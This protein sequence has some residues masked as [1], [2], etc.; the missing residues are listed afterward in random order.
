MARFALPQLGRWKWALIVPPVLVLLVAAFAYYALPGIVRGKLEQLLSEQLGRRVSVGAVEIVPFVPRVKVSDLAVHARDG[1]AVQFRFASLEARAAWRSLTERAPIL[2]AVRL[3]DPQLD[4]RR[5]PDGSYDVDDIVRKFQ[6][7]PK[8]DDGPMPAF[9]VANIELVGGRIG[10]DDRLVG[11][12]HAVRD[13]QIRVP[14][15]SSMPVHEKVV[16]DPLLAADVNGTPVRI[17][18]HTRPFSDTRDSVLDIDTGTIDLMQY[19]GYVPKPPVLLQ[20]GRLVAKLRVTFSQPPS[21]GAHVVVNG[22]AG[23]FGLAL[24]DPAGGPLLKLAALEVQ[25]INLRLIDRVF[26][27][28]TVDIA[29][30]DLSV[31]R[32]R[33]EA[34][35]FEPVMAV[36]DASRTPA[37]SP[38]VPAPAPAAGAPA[39]RPIQW[40]V[41][42]IRLTSARV[43]F[44]DENFEPR[45]LALDIKSADATVDALASGPGDTARWKL[46]LA[47]S[48]DERLQG[49]GELVLTPFAVRGNASVEGVGLAPW[50]WL[51]ERQL[52]LDATSGTVRAATRFDVATPDGGAPQVKLEGL[53]AEL[54]DL[55]L[56]QR[57]DRA[58][59]VK[60]S[61]VSVDDMALDL[62][63]RRV[64]I[65][66][67]AAG[68]GR[69]LLRR[70]AGGRMNVTR[71]VDPE[72]IGAAAVQPAPGAA[73]AG[74]AVKPARPG[75]SPGPKAAPR[76]GARS[77]KPP[78]RRPDAGRP[79][80][81]RQG[82]VDVGPGR[83]Q[84]AATVVPR[85]AFVLTADEPTSRAAAPAA[86][87]PAVA[88]QPAGSVPPPATVAGTD[89]AATP[90]TGSTP[91][92]A[93]APPSA[94]SA[95]PPPTT[96]STPQAGAAPARPADWQ[97]RIAR[98]DV[99]GLGVD[100]QD[101]TAGRA[102]DLK[103]ESL[104]LGAESLSNAR[105]SRGRVDLKGRVGSD[106]SLAIA[107]PLTIEPLA[108]QLKVDLQRI[109]VVP[110][111]P[112]FSEFV[113]VLVSS[114][115]VSLRGDLDVAM[116]AAGAAP[117][118]TWKGDAGVAD[119]AAVTKAG[120]EDLMRWKRLAL[121][122]TSVTLDPL[123]LDLGDITL[124][125]FYARLKIDA[126][127][128]FNLQDL[129][130]RGDGDAPAAA[131]TSAATASGPAP[132][133]TSPSA[134]S[135]A[136]A[137]ASASPDGS[138]AAAP[139]ES[140][141]APAAPPPR[142]SG[143][144]PD[145]RIGKVTLSNGRIEFTDLFVRPNYSADIRELSGSISQITAQTS[146]DVE[147]RGRLD[148]SG[149]VEITGAINP[150]APSAQL[151]LQARASD[152]DLPAL[153]PYSAKYVG[154]GIDKGKLSAT[155]RYRVE[156]RQLSAEN[157]IVLDQLTFGDKVDSPTALKLPVLFAVALLKDRNGVIDVNL[158]ISGSLDDPQ[159]SI[160]GIVLRI[161]GNLIVKAV[162]SPFALLGA[163]A[164]GGEQLSYLEFAPG[165]AALDPPSEKKL[166]SLAKAL[167]ERPGLRMD[168]AGRADPT[169]DR[170]ALRRQSLERLLKAQKLR[171]VVSAGGSVGGLD[172]IV[173]APEERE[174]YLRQALRATAPATP[175]APPSATPAPSATPSADG[176]APAGT[177]PR[178][179]GAPGAELPVAEVERQLL[180][181][182][183][184]DDAALRELA[185]DRSRV[186][187]DW[188]VGQ[189]KIPGERLFLVAPRLGG[190][191]LKPGEEPLR[192]DLSLKG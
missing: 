101:Q 79:A 104:R 112:Y 148:P 52:A 154:Y 74:P 166:E 80:A 61:A 169:R 28:G 181:R 184:V 147:L 42:S 145:M 10:F 47:T 32:N 98:L 54:R 187:R 25:D 92:A 84:A 18:G 159:F 152:I 87:A 21:G 86:D 94:G 161:I 156:N 122:G 106:G 164:G 175:T 124:A 153:S 116:R 155:V 75:T 46:S 142:P 105:D 23:V 163:L 24:N 5:G 89:P 8:G 135:A 91:A 141:A 2:S 144:P 58:D 180:D 138:P 139:P 66:R 35:F 100:V 188:L 172:E 20:S 157:N 123:K 88:G 49:E 129:V 151:N 43:A 109:G 27:V 16:V 119:F 11:T 131:T 185:N 95:G 111:Q 36:L 90:S 26:Q 64:D 37:R 70:D 162:T 55:A 14:F 192:V 186:A 118:V 63:A 133:S 97:W 136:S 3:V 39:T 113:N 179:R 48:A 13:L 103:L 83:P 44:A 117:R 77:A 82:A 57:W 1:D 96:A 168:L 143:P 191:G 59:L 73:P 160:S 189:G 127:G 107:G 71:L 78:P 167:T 6:S 126:Q 130:A 128:R 40:K 149:V 132:A 62:A 150:L 140:R 81:P 76:R 173:I 9:S 165:R 34:R 7:R 30:L 102:A 115:N 56:R 38:E 93:A 176:S 50:W 19:H 120:N 121:A 99:D 146:G 72:A 29:G 12:R 171:E 69:M 17:D 174:K 60:L 33:G 110:L 51:A 68:P 170:D 41:G 4:I 45:T 22:E 158:P 67:V 137:A 177:T 15:V 108:T 85:S 65:G 183:E 182:I 190:D 53:S 134:E 31:R 125:D 178:P 114:G